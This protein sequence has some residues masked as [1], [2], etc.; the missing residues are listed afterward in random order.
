MTTSI[1]CVINMEFLPP[2]RRCSSAWN[3]PKGEEQGETD[4]FA[5]YSKER[6][7]IY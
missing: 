3:A 4:V 2:S 7:D 5:G 1:D 6:G